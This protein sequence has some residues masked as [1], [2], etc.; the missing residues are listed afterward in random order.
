MH[1]SALFGSLVGTTVWAV[2][3]SASNVDV[4]G[5]LVAAGIIS[6]LS[7]IVFPNP[8]GLVPLQSARLGFVLFFYQ[9]MLSIAFKNGGPAQ[10]ALVNCNVVLICAYEIGFVRNVQFETNLIALACIT[11]VSSAAFVIYM[12]KLRKIEVPS[13]YGEIPDNE[14]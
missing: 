2:E 6:A 12:E 11:C 9:I 13:Q 1:N 3:L 5:P 7:L 14:P 4:R 10:Q 8:D